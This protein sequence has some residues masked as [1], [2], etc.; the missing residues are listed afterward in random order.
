MLAV[1]NQVSVLSLIPTHTQ[2]DEKLRAQGPCTLVQPSQALIAPHLPLPSVYLS[3][4][5]PAQALSVCLSVSLFV[6]LSICPVPI[7]SVAVALFLS[8]TPS[9]SKVVKPCLWFTSLTHSVPLVDFLS[10]SLSEFMS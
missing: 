5:L 9:L 10:V 2:L 7:V 1:I 3:A 6:R 8:L 4:C